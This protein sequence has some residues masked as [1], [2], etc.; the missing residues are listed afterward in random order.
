MEDEGH[1]HVH[2][3]P[4]TV[5]VLSQTETVQSYPSHSF[6]IHSNTKLAIILKSS[7]TY[8]IYQL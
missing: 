5:P 1:Y 8:F 2:H 4:P 7:K 3:G 6:K